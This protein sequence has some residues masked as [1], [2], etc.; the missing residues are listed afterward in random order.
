MIGVT[1]D[2]VVTIAVPIAVILIGG[3]Y[4]IGYKIGKVDEQIQTI[5]EDISDI[6]EDMKRHGKRSS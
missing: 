5:R 4:H 2:S 1:L 3:L 6:K